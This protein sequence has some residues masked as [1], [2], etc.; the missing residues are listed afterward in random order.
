MGCIVAALGCRWVVSL[1]HWVVLLPCWVAALDMMGVR[2][3]K[4]GFTPPGHVENGVRHDENG[5]NH[6]R[7][8]VVPARVGWLISTI[9]Q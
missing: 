3:D 2:R 6:P 1:P 4:E 8:I 5:G 7:H 9:L